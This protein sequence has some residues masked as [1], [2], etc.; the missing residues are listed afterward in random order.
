LHDIPSEWIG[1]DEADNID[2]GGLIE[3]VCGVPQVRI[4]FDNCLKSTFSYTLFPFPGSPP[5]SAW[6]CV[7]EP[8][9]LVLHTPMAHHIQGKNTPLAYRQTARHWLPADYRD[10]PKM[11]NSL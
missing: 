7:L 3:D 2:T 10:R 4:G 6:S 5:S 11:L 1:G 9:S 8:L